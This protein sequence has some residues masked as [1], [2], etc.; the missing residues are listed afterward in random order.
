MDP[1]DFHALS[2]YKW[3]TSKSSKTGGFYAARSTWDKVKKKKRTIKMHRLI[4][5]P[6]HP[7]VV[8]H[9]NHNGLDNRKANLRPATKSQNCIN[10]PLK[11]KKNAHSKYIGVTWQK[12]I[13]KWQA[14]I[15]A[16]GAH[17]VIGYF[18]NETD[19]AH[20]YDQAARKFHKE[21][22]VLNFNS[23]K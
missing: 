18:D 8:D 2:K 16:K 22:A 9:I 3:Q 15:R 23:K 12:S 19:A 17:R 1:E 20:A 7:L 14:Q 6:P 10:K 11:K 21:F 4:L 5:D 13:N